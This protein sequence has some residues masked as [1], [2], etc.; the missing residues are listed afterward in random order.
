MEI[1]MD[2]REGKL[3]FLKEFGVVLCVECRCCVAPGVVK[4]HFRD[5][6][7]HLG[8]KRKEINKIVAWMG[9]LDGLAVRVEDEKYPKPKCVGVSSLEVF[10]GG[11][12]CR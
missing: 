8:V 4:G 11:C 5:G 1:E 7:L 3:R 9:G 2:Y 10:L 6:K 12:I